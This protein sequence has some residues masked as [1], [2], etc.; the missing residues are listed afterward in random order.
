MCQ[1]HCFMVTRWIFGVR[2]KGMGVGGDFLL[3]GKP[4]SLEFGVRGCRD[5]M[6]ASE[7]VNLG[8]RREEGGSR[9]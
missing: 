1:I 7:I 9:S 4:L 5:A 3:F 8:F 6:L 2:W